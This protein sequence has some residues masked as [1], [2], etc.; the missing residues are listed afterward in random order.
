MTEI[1]VWRKAVLTIEEAA[2]YGSIGQQLLRGFVVLAKAGKSD[3]PVFFSGTSIKIPRIGFEAWLERM[4]SEHTQCELKTV[5]RM[6]ESLNEPDEP[7][8][9]RPRKNKLKG[10]S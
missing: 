7:K 4:G 10:A 3:F 8:R 6:I 9:G 1:P 5:Q 2:A